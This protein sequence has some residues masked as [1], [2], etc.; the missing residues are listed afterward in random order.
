VR[1]KR[2]SLGGATSL[3]EIAKT[4]RTIAFVASLVLF[5]ASQNLI[6]AEDTPALETSPAAPFLG[7]GACSTS[8]C[9]GGGGEKHDQCIRFNKLD[10]H[11]RSA[12]TLNLARSARIA[13]N[14]KI[15]DPVH[16]DRCTVCH[17]PFQAQSTTP[18]IA[19]V[20]NPAAGLNC[21]NC[22]GPA[23]NWL[24]SHTRPD[25]THQDRV[26]AGMRDLQSL[27]TRANTCVACHQNV[28]ADIL[29]AGHPELIF[30]LDGQSVSEPKHWREKPDW[31]GPQTW[32]VGQAV[33]LRE[34][35]WQLTH[36]NPPAPTA[37]DRWDAI[38]WL[39]ETAANNGP[40]VTKTPAHDETSAQSWS[41]ELAQKIS[42][43]PWTAESTRDCLNRLAGTAAEF[44]AASP[45][46]AVQA[47]R[48]ERLVLA[49]D[50]LVA[51][52]ND[53]AAAK[54]LD[55]PLAQLFKDAQ[56]LPDFNPEQ[57]AGHLETFQKA[58]QP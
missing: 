22:H 39:V 42:S 28:D 38:F 10:I 51:G 53:N 15:T 56:S 33:A 48:A 30:E 40:I 26:H 58:A 57:F 3:R 14:L 8:G 31:S 4:S 35:S 27:Y 32:L 23:Q 24:L 6:R 12:A 25:F 13:D 49:L 55:A 21:E 16:S 52:L 43:T 18:A 34:M 7:Q 54:R 29:K 1:S 5:A 46:R 50:R 2:F 11:T 17:E 19:K 47:R 36:E 45:T 41:D 44:R 37:H 20:L 9:H